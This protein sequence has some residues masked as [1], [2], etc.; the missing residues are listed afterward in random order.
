MKDTIKSNPEKSYSDLDS[1][2]LVS[3][4]HGV[5]LENIYCFSRM[6]GV[7]NQYDGPKLII[8]YSTIYVCIYVYM[9]VYFFSIH[10]S[11]KEFKL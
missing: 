8:D 11:W 9:D 7:C 1:S 2:P 5:L 10:G 6:A 4:M 3:S